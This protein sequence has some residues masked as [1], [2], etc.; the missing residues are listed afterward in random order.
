[1]A[2]LSKTGEVVETGGIEQALEFVR[3]NTHMEAKVDEGGRRSER[4]DYP[5][6]AIREA[7][8]NAVAHRDYTITVTDIE[9]SIYSDRLEVISPGRLPNT[10]T[11]EKI[12]AGYRASRNELMKEILRDYRYVEATGLGVPRKIVQGMRQHNGTDPDL[13]EEEDRF[14]VRLWMEPKRS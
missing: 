14:T 5:L 8:V 1:V 9:L 12:R 6:D 10:V 13:I 3:R 7:V 2:L 11:V 4:W